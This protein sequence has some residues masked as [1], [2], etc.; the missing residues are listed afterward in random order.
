MPMSGPPEDAVERFFEKSSEKRERFQNFWKYTR[1]ER[2]F[3]KSWSD[4][5]FSAYVLLWQPQKR[6]K[7]GIY[8][9]KLRFFLSRWKKIAPFWQETKQEQKVTILFKSGETK[10]GYSGKKLGRCKKNRNFFKNSETKTACPGEKLGRD[11]N[12][13]LFSKS[14]RVNDT[15]RERNWMGTQWR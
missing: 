11:K 8:E 7:K 4:F 12:F 3:E 5:G 15:H 9:K 1:C 10:T 13:G 2:F 6:L 14:V